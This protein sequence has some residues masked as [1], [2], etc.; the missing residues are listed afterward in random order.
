MT[1]VVQNI[2]VNASVECAVSIFGVVMAA[3]HERKN[4]KS[5]IYNTPYKHYKLEVKL[6]IPGKFHEA[7]HAIKEVEIQKKKINALCTTNY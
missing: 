6:A 1:R 4:L 5:L 2:R 3:R 7:V